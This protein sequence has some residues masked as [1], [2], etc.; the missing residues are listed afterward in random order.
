[1]ATLVRLLEGHP[2]ALSIVS[3]DFE[4]SHELTIREYVELLQNEDQRL[5][6]L[7]D[8]ADSSRRARATIEI[9][10]R[11]LPAD[12]Q[13]FFL[14][15]PLFEESD[16]DSAAVAAAADKPPLQIKKNLGRLCA[17]TLVEEVRY[18]H[19]SHLP[20]ASEKMGQASDQHIRYRLHSLIRLFA[21]EKAKEGDQ[22]INGSEERL[23]NHY[24]QLVEKQSAY[25]FSSLQ[26]DIEHILRSLTWLAQQGKWTLYRKTVNNLT[27]I[28]LGLAGFLDSRG[29]WSMAIELLHR[30][31]QDETLTTN[32]Q[33]VAEIYLKLALFYERQG[34]QVEA[35]AHLGLAEKAMLSSPVS[36]TEHRFWAYFYQLRGRLNPSDVLMWS[37]RT[38]EQIQQDETARASYEKGYFLIWHGSVLGRQGMRDPARE[39]TQQGLTLLPPE[40]NAARIN[41]LNALG[42]LQEISGD[43]QAAIT[44]WQQAMTS[45]K[46]V[47]DLRREGMLWANIGATES[48]CGRL[49]DAIVN[50]QAALER[51]RAVGFLSGQILTLSNLAAD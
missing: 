30:C 50:K 20:E 23:A 8:W 10:Y 19:D 13:K 22:S 46:A 42:I 3:S 14:L 12:L 18:A 11:H 49:Q 9:S 32:P 45:A 31:L 4:A 25:P 24:I 38:L 47:G 5:S 1:M 37:R 7:D 21:I 41:G 29:H 36:P 6:H 43:S 40:A 48:R 16:F 44:S 28:Q 39:D 35:S 26:Q 27:N 15:L 33:G 34:K 2:L 51:Y 17:L